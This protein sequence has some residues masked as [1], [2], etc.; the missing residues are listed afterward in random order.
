MQF[1]RH[2]DLAGKHAFM[3]AS[4][5]SWIRYD[6]EKI[7]ET[8]M[9]SMTAQRGTELH[10][11]AAEAIRLGIRLPRTQ[12][13]L[14]MYVNDALSY[15]M[16]PEVMLVATPNAF[17]TTDTISFRRERGHDKTV[18]RLHDLKNGVNKTSVNQLEIYAAFFCLE[19][20]IKPHEIDMELRIYQNDY[21]Q[22][23]IP[24]PGDILHIM[25]KTMLFDRLINNAR[26]EVFA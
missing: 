2:P 14:N 15:R 19:Y 20:G 18:L 23:Y 10:A 4:K 21:V 24:E 17:G 16:K 12:A 22:V 7:I 25:D 13:T 9:N 5:Y 1:N 8:F 3:S 26:M 6:E 11:F